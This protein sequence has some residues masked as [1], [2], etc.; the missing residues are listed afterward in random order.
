MKQDKKKE[1]AQKIRGLFDHVSH[2]REV[3]DPNYLSGLS[4]EEKKSFNKYMILRVLSMDASIIDMMAFLSKYINNV[5]D[6]QFYKVLIDIVPKGKRFCKYI[7]KSSANI[8]P[9]ILECICNKFKVCKQDAS[10]YYAILIGNDAGLKELTHLV[11]GF[12]FSEIETEK[13]FQ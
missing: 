1:S 10:D 2:I 12:G 9:T 6:E 3:K 4:V 11:Q 13:M 7:K 8:N 5:P